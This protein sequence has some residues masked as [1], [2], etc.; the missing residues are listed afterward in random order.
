LIFT[1]RFTWIK[2][3]VALLLHMIGGKLAR[4]AVSLQEHAAGYQ[5]KLLE[6]RQRIRAY[7]WNNIVLLSMWAL[8][9]LVCGSALFF[10]IYLLSLS[11]AGAWVSC[12]SPCSIIS[13]TPTRAT[14]S[15]GTTNAGA[16]EGTSFLALP[17]WLNWFYRQY[18]LSPYHHL[19]A[20]IPNY[21]LVECP[22]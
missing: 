1:P 4:P 13:S 14:A 6:E 16:I 2:G 10:T 17:G 22:R 3:T 21:R 11:I 15:D 19:S 18:R 9:C 20:N 12:C 5:T 7:S 8:M